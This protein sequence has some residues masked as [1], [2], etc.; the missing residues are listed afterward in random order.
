MFPVTH[1]GARGFTMVELMVTLAIFGIMLAIGVPA[2]SKWVVQS[3]AS[4]AGELYSEGFAMARRQAVSHNAE[5]RIVL[6]PNVNNGQ[7][8][9][10]VDICFPVTGT[11]CS[12]TSGTWSTPTTQASGDPEGAN[13]YTSVFRAAD[14]LPQSAIL[15]PTLLP[16]GTST[17]YFT[18]LGWVDT[19]VANRLTRIQLDPAPQYS[20]Q[21]PSTAVVVGLAGMAS[22][23]NPAVQSPDSRACPP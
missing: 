6:T 11:P 4:G 1:D 19:S 20:G 16:D 2:M 15:V 5:S 3:K 22:T 13:G 21:I 12:D 18:A 23:C 7:M 10:Q 14:A 9:W 8:D 17:I